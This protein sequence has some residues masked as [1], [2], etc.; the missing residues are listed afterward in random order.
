MKKGS[1][2]GYALGLVGLAVT[3]YVV[4]Y[5]FKKGSEAGA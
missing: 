2:V 3:V 1:L 4:G 5:A